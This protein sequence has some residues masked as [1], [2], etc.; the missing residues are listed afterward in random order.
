MTHGDNLMNEIK[1]RKDTLFA[2]FI[3]AIF[4]AVAAY[5]SLSAVVT[6]KDIKDYS[7]IS[8]NPY[9][10]YERMMNGVG[11]K[12]L[13]E[14][15]QFKEFKYND[16]LDNLIQNSNPNTRDNLFDESF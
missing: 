10:K 3:F 9:E 11:I 13:V 16:K 15:E 8:M 5:Y 7:N 4:V 12:N 6:E 1:N 2:L 14:N